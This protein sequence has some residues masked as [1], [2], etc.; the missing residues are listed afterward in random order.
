MD[1]N[2]DDIILDNN[3]KSERVKKLLLRVIALV[4]LFLVVMIV[5][6]LL[7]SGDENKGSQTLFPA[8]P[9]TSSEF[10]NIPINNEPN[11]NELDEFT[12][13]KLQMQGFE[14]NVSV[15]E[16]NQSFTMPL[17]SSEYN[18]SAPAEP[19]ATPKPAQPAKPAT[20]PEQKPKAE[21]KP[22]AQKPKAESKPAA[23]KPKAEPKPAPKPADKPKA[24]QNSAQN[25]SDL[26]S[27]AYVQ[28]FSVKNFDTKSRELAL[29]T[30]NGYK[31]S[32]RKRGETTQILIG[33]FSQDELN[34]ELPKIRQTISKDAFVVQVK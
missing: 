6:K 2:F 12:A 26:Q 15:L 8:E 11:S 7:N 1:K 13:L 27:G 17:P 18:T 24:A 31:Y 25:A 5:M 9:N 4:I 34:A 22:A 14:S 29:V 19:A 30:Q 23:Q 32:T 3:N 20:K 10:D 16:S 21:S 33:P 28:V